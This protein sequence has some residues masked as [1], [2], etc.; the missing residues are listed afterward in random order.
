MLR[1]IL[2]TLATL[3]TLTTGLPSSSTADTVDPD[4]IRGVTLDRHAVVVSSRLPSCRVEDASRGPV[5]CTWNVNGNDG[6]GR[7]LAFVATDR[8]TFRYVWASDPTSGTRW[9]WA[10]AGL[11]ETLDRHYG[12]RDERAGV[13]S[14]RHCAWVMRDGTA[15]GKCPSGFRWIS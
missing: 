1:S 14:F 7:G 11:A 4:G 10:R 8:E 15:F 13:E 9:Q 12:K 3:A 2:I 5:P 6:N